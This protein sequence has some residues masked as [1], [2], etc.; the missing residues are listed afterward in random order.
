MTGS[1][2]IL[3]RLGPGVV[4]LMA[5]GIGWFGMAWACVAQ[6]LLT[7]LP[8]A[9]GPSASQVTVE[10][11]EVN[12]KAEVRWNSTTGQVL[13]TSPEGAG[14]TMAVT[15]PPAAPG[16]YSLVLVTR[17]PDGGVAAVGRASFLVTGSDGS[18]PAEPAAADP[19]SPAAKADAPGTSPAAKTGFALLGAGLVTSGFVLARLLRRRG[20]QP[21]SAG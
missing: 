18:G 15:I 2:R 1:H 13:G 16:L 14:F 7:V 4:T 3:R 19:D 5:V 8:R 20:P 9:S 6:P 11:V 17:A 21:I 10:A 12:A